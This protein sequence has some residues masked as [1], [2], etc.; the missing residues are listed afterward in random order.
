MGSGRQHLR[1]SDAHKGSLFAKPS[2]FSA[3]NKGL[4]G[5]TQVL[6][7]LPTGLVEVFRAFFLTIAAIANH[8]NLADFISFLTHRSI[9]PL[10]N[11]ENRSHYHVR[12][13]GICKP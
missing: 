2:T 12:G 6:Q 5:T 11:N 10:V 9:T 13:G 8:D 3:H 1:T 7:T 4:L